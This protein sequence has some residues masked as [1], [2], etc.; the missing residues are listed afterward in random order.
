[1]ARFVIP[2]TD[3]KV[4]KMFAACEVG[5]SKDV[6]LTPVEKSGT[7]LTVDAEFV[8]G[9]YDDEDDTAEP[10]ESEAKVP[11]SVIKAGMKG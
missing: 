8:G 6:T 1:M 3:P 9:E 5:E 7:S 2:L 4:K 11:K 10:V